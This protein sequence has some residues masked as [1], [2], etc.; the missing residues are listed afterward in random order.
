MIFFQYKADENPSATAS[1]GSKQYVFEGVTLTADDFTRYLCIQEDGNGKWKSIDTQDGR[2]YCNA[3]CDVTFDDA[4]GTLIFRDSD[5]R[6]IVDVLSVFPDEPVSDK[7]GA[8][9]KYVEADIVTFLLEGSYTTR[10]GK[11][12]TFDPETLKASG[13]L[14]N[15]SSFEIGTVMGAPAPILII[16]GEARYVEKTEESIN[17]LTLKDYDGII[18]NFETTG[19]SIELF[20]TDDNLWQSL[21]KGILTKSEILYYAGYS[22]YGPYFDD[23]T[24]ARLL[25]ARNYTLAKMEQSIYARHGYTFKDNK[26]AL[27]WFQFKSWYKSENDEVKLTKE[28]QVNIDLIKSLLNRQFD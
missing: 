6:E 18:G 10:E 8:F 1:E 27:G 15:D 22:P 20:R 21:T 24:V 4:C 26:E 7:I 23:G 14:F 13:T 12:V 28:E 2:Y 17:L 19:A 5:S 3:N 25:A 9:R 11:T 16:D